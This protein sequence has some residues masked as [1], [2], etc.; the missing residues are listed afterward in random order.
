MYEILQKLKSLLNFKI[1]TYMY[2]FRDFLLPRKNILE[3]VGIQPGFYVLDY[4]CGPGSYLI[5]LAELV[6]KSGKIYTLD[7]NPLAIFRVKNI[8]SKRGLENVETILSNCKTVLPDNSIEVVLLYNTF[9]D[10]DDPDGVLKELSRALKSKGKLSF[11][12]HHMK[13]DKILFGLTKRDL[14]MLSKKGKRTILFI[15]KNNIEMYLP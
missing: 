12:D 13:E 3:E 11:S 6:G 15:K 7:I 1:M 2:R 14:F 8:A 4:G 9:H 10:L 5:P